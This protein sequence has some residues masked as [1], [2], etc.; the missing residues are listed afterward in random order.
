MTPD[1]APDRP[2]PPLDASHDNAYAD[3]FARALLMPKKEFALRVFAGCSPTVLAATFAVP[4][5]RVIER[6]IE[7]DLQE[8]AG[9]PTIVYTQ[10]VRATR[11]RTWRW[12]RTHRSA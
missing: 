8:F 9:L 2:V 5:E 12:R 6:I 10:R 11:W 3:K 7:L 4:L 1:T